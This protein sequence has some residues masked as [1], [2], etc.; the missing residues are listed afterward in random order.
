MELV[1]R[2]RKQK[3]KPS[4][5][6]STMMYGKVPPQAKDLEEA[7]LGAIMQER[8]AFDAVSSILVPECFYVDA[9]Q[10]IFKT[11]IIMK[12]GNVPIDLLTTVEEL[13]KQE[14]LDMVGGPYYITKLTNAVVSS[15]HIEYHAKIIYQKYLGREIIRI[16][17]YTP[18]Y[19]T[20]DQTEAIRF[21]TSFATAF[22]NAQRAKGFEVTELS[23]KTYDDLMKD[24]NG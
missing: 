5:D 11:F 14:E 7:V 3:R 13:K 20:V 4:V 8:N 16:E 22:A 23:G 6:L 2:D 10:R 24:I 15:A 21:M 9:H 1:N 17:D 18:I 12:A 19:A